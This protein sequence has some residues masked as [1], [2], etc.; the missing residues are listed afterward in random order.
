MSVHASNK[1]ETSKNG[2]R[3]SV[4]QREMGQARAATDADEAV[5]KRPRNSQPELY[6]DG[7]VADIGGDPW[8]LP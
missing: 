8:S 7:T 4:E 6:I 2:K 3:P 5:S 1:R